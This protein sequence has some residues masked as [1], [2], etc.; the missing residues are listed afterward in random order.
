MSAPLEP[1]SDA[2]GELERTLDSVNPEELPA[3]AG[4]HGRLV[5]ARCTGCGVVRLKR[6]PPEKATIDE[7]RRESFR[8]VCHADGCQK[9]TWWNILAVRG[10][11]A[12]GD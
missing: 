6:A 12:R 11:E 2:P 4:E 5:G 7:D 1:E 8:H 9:V 3:D 10:G